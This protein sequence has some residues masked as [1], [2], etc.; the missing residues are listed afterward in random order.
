ML[1]VSRLVPVAIL[2]L[3]S[4]I[5]SAGAAV[6][7]IGAEEAAAWA[8]YLVPLPRT[9]SITAKNQID[10]NTLAIYVPAS[11]DTVTT[12]ARK[13]L[14]ESM[15]L[16]GTHSNP[17]SPAFTITL[18]IGGAESTPLTSL[19]NSDQ[20]YLI[21]VVSGN[22][23]LKIVALSSRGLYYGAKTVQQLIAAYGTA[24]GVR[25]PILTAT[26][27]PE[28]KDRGVWGNDS[29]LLTRWMADRKLNY[30]EQIA[31]RSLDGNC[32]GQAGAKPGYEVLYQEGPTY[33]LQPCYALLH[34]EQ[35][36]SGTTLFT[37]YPIVQG[38]SAA[39]GVWCYTRPVG[40]PTA[41]DVLAWW[42]GDLA[43]VPG[44]TDADVWMSES[45]PSGCKCSTCSVLNRNVAEV[46]AIVAGW[47]KAIQSVGPIGLRILTSESTR[48]DNDLIVAELASDPTVKIWH[49]DSLKT[50]MVWEGQVVDSDIAAWA[51]SGKYAGFV[52]LLGATAS[53]WQPWTG[54]QFVRYRMQEAKNKSLSG[55]MGYP[56]PGIAYNRFNT[57]AAAEWSWNPDGR[58]SREFAASW[59]V[60]QGLADPEMFADW[61]ELMGPVSWDIYG[62]E[63]PR[64][65]KR[66]NARCGPI[67]T[68][69]VNGTLQSLGTFKSGL[70]PAPWG[71]IKSVTQF[72]D[73]VANAT[74]ALA[75][76]KRMNV[77]EFYYESL[78]IHGYI[79][80]LR[81]LYELKSLVV[82]G[83]VSPA[84]RPAAANY[85]Y[86]YVSGFK[87]AKDALPLWATAIGGSTAAVTDSV[88]LLTTEISEM[89]SLASSLGCPIGS[90]FTLVPATTIPEAKT[91]ADGTFVSLGGEIVTSTTNG[92]YV[93]ESIN[94]PAGIKLQTSLTTTLNTSYAIL[95]TMGTSNGE[96]YLNATMVVP[97]SAAVSG[98]PIAMKTAAI[99]GGA[100]GLQSAVWEYKGASAAATTGIS[101]VGLNVKIAGK[102]TAHGSTW[103]YLDDGCN[104]SD[105]SGSVGVRVICG[106]I[107]KPSVGSWVM[108]T[109]PSST[110]YERSHPWRAVVV[111]SAGNIR[112][113]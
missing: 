108:V 60:R 3:A 51:A 36:Y 96:R 40:A 61:C 48:S 27:Y 9:Y 68:A 82:G 25:I 81:A 58:T 84:N 107:T 63:W 33:G 32:I 5:L 75:L 42:I 74:R 19:K 67:A 104:L 100:F 22:T 69:L 80:A 55:L 53:Y 31:A 79:T 24:G 71:D 11:P 106:S 46:R 29:Y 110:Y 8:R 56:T 62:S 94:A 70:F 101:N 49:Y 12:Q 65:I 83:A 37:C 26:D 34:L 7:T 38:V 15:G 97:I 90:T 35:V 112:P 99:G 23:G 59:A 88:S 57:E 66:N 10:P 45:V 78:V 2:L 103:F 4:S 44:C 109:G 98:R 16:P 6:Q 105:G 85:F 17:A 102:V 54:P 21:L 111:T 47:K 41:V 77:P 73:D 52:P 18:Q 76:A 43:T 91:K 92:L 93:Q 39:T 14:W 113:I 28:L 1:R 30:Q 87:Q 86:I 64:G 13:E 72:N 95:G 50:Y 20:A 89:T